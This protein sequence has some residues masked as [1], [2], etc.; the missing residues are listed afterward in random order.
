MECH[1]GIVSVGG[2][3]GLMLTVVILRIG[4]SR[5]HSTA[6]QQ[7]LLERIAPILMQLLTLGLP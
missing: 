6:I 2:L 4:I 7:A 3:N 5:I 1:N